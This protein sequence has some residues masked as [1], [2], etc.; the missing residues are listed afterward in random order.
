MRSQKRDAR[1]DEACGHERLRLLRR[2][3]PDLRHY[4]S[5]AGECVDGTHQAQPQ[6]EVTQA[7]QVRPR[8]VQQEHST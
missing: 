6:R 4:P 7:V 3:R 2:V 1:I 5:F 8:N